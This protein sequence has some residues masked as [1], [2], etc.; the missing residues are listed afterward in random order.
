MNK[1]LPL[2]LFVAGLTVACGSIYAQGKQIYS[3]KDADGVVHY[4]DTPPNNPDAVSMDA[5]E[6]YRPGTADAYPE[7]ESI[8]TPEPGTEN[9]AEIPDTEGGDVS[10]ADQKRKELAVER[11]RRRQAQAEMSQQCAEARAQLERL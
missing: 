7:K 3:W 1:S 5:P 6:V 4:V 8:D 11:E 10:Y 9:M 2:F